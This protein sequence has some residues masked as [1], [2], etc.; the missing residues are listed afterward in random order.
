M[1]NTVWFVKFVTI[2]DHIENRIGRQLTS[3]EKDDIVTEIQNELDESLLFILS[4]ICQRL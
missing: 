2:E 1:K 3:G 4:D